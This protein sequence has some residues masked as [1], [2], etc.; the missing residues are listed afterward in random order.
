M[1][2]DRP[3]MVVMGSGLAGARVVAETLERAPNGFDIRMFGAE[4]HATYNRILLSQ[5]LGGFE[6][7][8]P[9]W[10]NTREWYE[11]RGVHLH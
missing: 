2:S 10:L 8:Q 11:E 6:G 3:T 4:P 5:V 1:A 7:D 9:L